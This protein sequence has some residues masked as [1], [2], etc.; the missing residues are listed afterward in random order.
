MSRAYARESTRSDDR[1][2]QTHDDYQWLN[3]EDGQ[4]EVARNGR[5]QAGCF[6]SPPV[7]QDTRGD[8]C[9]KHDPGHQDRPGDRHGEGRMWC[10]GLLALGGRAAG[11]GLILREHAL[12]YGFVGPALVHRAIGVGTARHPGFRRGKPASAYGGVPG[13]EAETQEHG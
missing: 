2:E 10:V 11:V 5:D 4:E 6:R 1:S 12:G 9:G 3:E 13:D 7:V 8:G